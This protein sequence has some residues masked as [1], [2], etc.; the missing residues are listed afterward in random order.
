MCSREFERLRRKQ[1]AE[2][3]RKFALVCQKSVVCNGDKDC[4][5]CPH[6]LRELQI[7]DLNREKHVRIELE[8]GCSCS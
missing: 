7:V 1:E 6:F 5:K 2:A 4:L 3:S 8:E